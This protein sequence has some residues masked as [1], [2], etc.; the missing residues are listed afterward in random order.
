MSYYVYILLCKDGTFYTGYT[1]SVDERAKLHANGRG[2][3]YTKTHPPQKVAYVEGFTSRAEA[4]R[5]E[6]A[7]K[8]LSHRQKQD[9]IDSQKNGAA[10]NG[11]GSSEE[12]V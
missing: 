3:R 10:Q 4:M 5:R 11:G 2:A 6:R 9:L 7:I 12:Q 8:K 1:K